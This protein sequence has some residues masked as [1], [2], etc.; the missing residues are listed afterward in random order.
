MERGGHDIPT[1]DVEKRFAH[2]FADVLKILPYCDEAKSF[3]NDNGFVLVA[4]YRNGQLLPIGTCRPL[5]L[6][7]LLEKL[8]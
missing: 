3:D 6:E 2:R 5:W 1:K 4:E 8:Q 7:Q